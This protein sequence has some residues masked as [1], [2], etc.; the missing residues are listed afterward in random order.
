MSSA[1]P[2]YTELKEQLAKAE[3][4]NRMWRGLDGPASELQ[5]EF[6][7]FGLPPPPPGFFLDDYDPNQLIS[8]AKQV[9]LLALAGEKIEVKANVFQQLAASGHHR[10][11]T[12]GRQVSVNLGNWTQVQT[13]AVQRVHMHHA[14]VAC[15]HLGVCYW[16]LACV[17][18]AEL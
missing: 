1:E 7:P 18:L 11:H 15:Y 8:A 4:E 6:G 10:L 16:G 3:A 13:A 12:F 5:P 2:S 17:R 14:F 9:L